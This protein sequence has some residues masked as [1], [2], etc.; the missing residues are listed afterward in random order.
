MKHMA[1]VAKTT[2]AFPC[3]N[4]KGFNDLGEIEFAAETTMV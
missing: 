1:S 2:K 4:N 3:G